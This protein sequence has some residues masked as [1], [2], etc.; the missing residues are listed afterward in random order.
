MSGVESAKAI[1]NAMLREAMRRD[2]LPALPASEVVPLV[3]GHGEVDG[4]FRINGLG[5]PEPD[6][7]WTVA[8]AAMVRFRVS[9]AAS[10][11]VL[12]YLPLQLG[13]HVAHAE[14]SIDDGPWHPLVPGA[15]PG[16]QEIAVPL[17]AYA[18]GDVA[19]RIRVATPLVPSA[20][21][22]GADSR[23][24]G[25]KLGSFALLP[26]VDGA[27]GADG[28][29]EPE[30]SAQTVC[31]TTPVVVDAPLNTVHPLARAH[32]PA[33][34][35]P[36]LSQPVP[37]PRSLSSRIA[38]A[39]WRSR[40][41]RPF[42]PA[43]RGGR[44]GLALIRSMHDE[45]AA[46]RRE[47]LRARIDLQDRVLDLQRAIAS[48][49]LQADTA[50]GALRSELALVE[51]RVAQA[52]ES[53]NAA[54]IAR[55]EHS[56][57]A[58]SDAAAALSASRDLLDTVAR[59]QEAWSSRLN[60]ALATA[61]RHLENQA[62]AVGQ[63]Q[64]ALASVQGGVERAHNA[65]ER[66]HDAVV[67]V[68]GNVQRLHDAAVAVR[69]DIER[70]QETASSRLG[71]ALEQVA[72]LAAKADASSASLDIVQQQGSYVRDALNELVHWKRDEF[73]SHVQSA[74]TAGP[75]T[76]HAPGVAHTQALLDRI[77]AT[78]DVLL[79][80][81]R[82][83]QQLILQRTDPLLR[84]V[85]LPD[86]ERWIVRSKF[87]YL[88]VPHRER[89]LAAVLIEEGDVEPGTREVIERLLDSG[90]TFVDVGANLGIHTIA[91]AR[92]VGATGRVVAIEPTPSLHRYLR[93]SLEL[94]GVTRI[95]Q[96][97]PKAVVA[98][99]GEVTLHCAENSGLNS[100]FPLADASST[101]VVVPATTLDAILAAESRVDLIK[102]DVEG[103]ELEAMAGAAK[104]MASHP[105]LALVVEYGPSHLR[106]TG[107]DP[108]T[109]FCTFLQGGREGFAIQ[110]DGRCVRVYD[111]HS[112]DG[113]ESVNLVFAV[114]GTDAYRRLEAPNV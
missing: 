34:A 42:H 63:L 83:A 104:T 15:D 1:R 93:E 38:R 10:V 54:V 46:L 3:D 24:L 29:D 109:W 94:N 35:E 86:P 27:Q 20:L 76:A 28:H 78:S 26:R 74:H 43:V 41:F 22:F 40:L 67:G 85:V 95:V 58:W 79:G 88:C 50:S 16:W 98:Q 25:V 30:G 32:P 5:A 37:S 49:A 71:A 113:V 68:E 8:P 110:P 90:A 60:D 23:Q 72:G 44:E 84:R 52:A 73:A 47:Q 92:R 70:L 102:L 81:L 33:A 39:V 11:A 56:H 57:A 89:W 4:R 65:A 66:T 99:P 55:L 100:I 48:N 101:S 53:A 2:H 19:C 105:H 87:G 31:I 82:A 75:D 12:R 69:A 107:I 13:D 17:P 97:E 108:D 112:L 36:P 91:A 45:V 96:V 59:D 7:L 64:D 114:P 61:I 111:I 6:G 14:A 9:P 18:K 77:T 51:A 103:A 21:G 62:G 106:R 80:Q